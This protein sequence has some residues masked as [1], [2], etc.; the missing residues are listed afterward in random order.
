[1]IFITELLKDLSIII[2]AGAVISGINA[3]KREHIGKR[4]IELAEDTLTLFYQARGVIRDIR[5]P[6]GKITEGNTRPK[7]KHESEDENQLLNEAYVV[8]ER[9]QKQQDVFN[10]LLSIRYRFMAR[11]GNETENL[12]FELMKILEDIFIAAKKWVI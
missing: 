3:W 5:C 9:Y 11:F 8:F 2:S 4:Q 6:H 7:H 1:M 12:F 10:K